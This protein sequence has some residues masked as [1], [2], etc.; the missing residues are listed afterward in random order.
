MNTTESE[1]TAPATAR[2]ARAASMTPRPSLSPTRYGWRP[3]VPS[4]S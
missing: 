1:A 2:A 3:A 4:P